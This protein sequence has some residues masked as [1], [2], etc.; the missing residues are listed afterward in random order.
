MEDAGNLFKPVAEHVT[1]LFNEGK[2]TEGWTYHGETLWRPKHNTLAYKRVP[3]NHF[4]LYAVRTGIDEFLSDWATMARIASDIECEPVPLLYQGEF[5]YTGETLWEKLAEL[6]GSESILG[7]VEPEGIVVKNFDQRVLIGGQVIP[8]LC[9]KFV[10]E[11][12]KEKHKV[13]WKVSNPNDADKIFAA[14]KTEARWHKAIQ[15]RKESSDEDLSVRDIGVLIKSIQ[16]DVAEEERD[17]I[18][19]MLWKMWKPKILRMSTRGFPEWFKEELVK[20]NLNV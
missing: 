7:G 5:P 2:L 20:G 19:E 6:M 16:N 17:W 12:F 9:G 4:A 15:R 18:K 3:H 13:D 11:K 8:I 14:L 1:K 10:T